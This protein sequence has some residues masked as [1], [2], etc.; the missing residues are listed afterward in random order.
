VQIEYGVANPPVDLYSP[1]SVPIEQTTIVAF[2]TDVAYF[3]SATTKSLL[4]GPG[5]IT[6]AHSAWEYVR[7]AD[8]RAA[9][10]VYEKTIIE[11]L[12]G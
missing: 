7:V 2:N 3:K 5:S 12:A 4:Y 8:L 1:P 10:V 9:C 11:L 6:D